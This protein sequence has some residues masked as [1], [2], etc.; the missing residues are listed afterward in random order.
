M[1]I[2]KTINK[3][4]LLIAATFVAIGIS[5]RLFPHEA[6]FAPVGAI[7][8]A[9]GALLGRRY[10]IG[11]LLAIMA[12]T[13]LIIGTYSG[14]MF[15]WSAFALVG[16]Y[17]AFF[18]NASFSSRVLFGS[19]GSASIFF[20]VS[21]FGTWVSSGMYAHTF[22]GLIQCYYMAI[23]FFRA[24]FVSDLIYSGA[25]FGTVAIVLAIRSYGHAIHQSKPA[26]V[27]RDN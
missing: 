15:T 19:L 21:N 9:S 6:N 20:V 13:D 16:L 5:F 2:P 17:G 27:H 23:P 14:M 1:E 3:R 25:I 11:I 10:A 26:T 4:A 18:R 7:A 8:L 24:T 22:S 12:V